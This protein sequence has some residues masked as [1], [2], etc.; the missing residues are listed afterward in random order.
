MTFQNRSRNNCIRSA[1]FTQYV[2]HSAFVS[3]LI[4]VP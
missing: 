1:V 4:Y 3:R 2:L